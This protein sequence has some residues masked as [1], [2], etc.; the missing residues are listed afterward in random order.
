MTKMT[1]FREDA[2]LEGMTYR[3]VAGCAQTMG[4]TAG[5]AVDALA[6]QLPEDQADTL[7]IV[8]DLRPDRHFTT[9][10]RQRLEELMTRWRAARDAGETLPAQ[11]QAE[12]ER[13]VD[14]EVRAAA[15]RATAL[16]HE[17]AP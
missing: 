2:D 17:L 9:E 16:R 11:D 10:Q 13:L 4:R 5:E 14:E 7:I 8:R 1:I 3:A 15:E 6:A 12:L